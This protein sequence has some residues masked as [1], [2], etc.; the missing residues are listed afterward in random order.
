ML[1]INRG[2]ALADL[3]RLSP[4]GSMLKRLWD[5]KVS[6]QEHGL[7]RTF[8]ESAGRELTGEA[9][10]AVESGYAVESSAYHLG[11]GSIPMFPCRVDAAPGVKLFEVRK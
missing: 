5:D 7:V 10:T 11:D 8:A 4:P 2:T 9:L 1:S 3:M 6:G